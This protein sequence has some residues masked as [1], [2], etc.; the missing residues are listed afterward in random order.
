MGNL[1]RV[2]IVGI[3][4][5]KKRFKITFG[6]WKYISNDDWLKMS[7]LIGCYYEKWIKWKGIARGTS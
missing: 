2:L 6:S 5:E 4:R 1:D 3:A 7:S